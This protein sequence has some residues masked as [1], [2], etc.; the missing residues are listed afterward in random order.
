M[1]LL[2]LALL[3]PVFIAQLAFGSFTTAGYVFT[4]SDHVCRYAGNSH[5]RLWLHLFW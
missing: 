3:T 4:G 5:L 1:V 2:S